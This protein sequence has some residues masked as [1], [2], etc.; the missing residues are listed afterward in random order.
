MFDLH[1]FTS[2]VLARLKLVN[3]EVRLLGKHICVKHL[4]KLLSGTQVYYLLLQVALM[5]E[6]IREYPRVVHI[7]M[8]L[9]QVRLTKMYNFLRFT[10][11][12][13]I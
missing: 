2:I 7:P 10:L 3:N 12:L 13:P 6:A 1:D 4:N 8:A 11:I 9:A 5:F